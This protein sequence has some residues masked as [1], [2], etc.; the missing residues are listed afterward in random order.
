MQLDKR[1]REDI[2]QEM[3]ELAAGYTPEWKFRARQGDAGSALLNCYS[4]MLVEMLHQYNRIPELHKQMFFQKLGT[5][6]RPAE[7]AQGYVSFGLIHPEAEGTPV[8]A[9]TG[10]WGTSEDGE[11]VKLETQKEIYVSNNRIEQVMYQDGGNDR[12]Y[13]LAEAEGSLTGFNG[14][15][16]QEHVCWLGHSAVF[17][18][19]GEAE[20]LISFQP[21]PGNQNW[22]D[23]IQNREKT[24]FSY[25]S[26]QGEWKFDTWSCHSHII[27]LKKTRD[28]PDFAVVDE[29]KG[30]CC[31]LKWQAEDIQAYTGLEVKNLRVGAVSPVLLPDYVYTAEGQEVTQCFFPFGERPYS[32]GECYICS[33]E[34]FEKRGAMVHL[35]LNIEFRKR[36]LLREPVPLPIHWKAIMK[37]SDF[38][39]EECL[40]ITVA[41]VVWEYYNGTGFTRLFSQP[42]YTDI[43][44]PLLQEPADFEKPG[45]RLENISFLCPTD[46]VPIPVNAETV[47]CVRIRILRMQHEYAA[48]G[49]YLSPFITRIEASYDYE[50]SMQEPELCRCRNN[51]EEYVHT[52]EKTFAPFLPQTDSQSGI[53]IGFSKP[54][55]GGPY[56]IYCG[57]APRSAVNNSERWNYEY[58]NGR[59]WSSLVLEDETGNLTQ[60]GTL[61]PFGNYDMQALPLFGR[62]RY[63]LRLLLLS[64]DRIAGTGRLP[65]QEVW[66]NTVSVAAVE[67]APEE[68]LTVWEAEGYL[69]CKLKQKNIRQ[70]QVWVNEADLSLTE[71]EQ[72][73]QE[74]EVCKVR[75]EAGIITQVW[76]LWEETEDI[77][78]LSPDSRCYH[79]ER[80]EGILQFSGENRRFLREDRRKNQ[81]KAV[82]S[83][84]GGRQGNLAAG[85]VTHMN[86]SIRFLNQVVNRHKL[87]GGKDEELPEEAMLRMEHQLLHR[88]RAVMPGDYEA[89][90][91]ESAREVTRVK[92]FANRNGRGE[93][94]RGAITLVVLQEDPQEEFQNL[95]EVIDEYIRSRMPGIRLV[96]KHFYIVEPWFTEIQVTA[97]CRI[98]P[99]ASVFACKAEAEERLGRFLNPLTGNSDG[100]G[101]HIGQAPRR[102]QLRNVLH[103]TKGILQLRR[104]VVKAYCR[105]EERL[106]EVN[107]EGCLPEFLM[108]MNGSH[109]L[110]MEFSDG[111]KEGEDTGCCR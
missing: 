61:M 79:V 23:V 13:C 48:K 25:V 73:E 36:S 9:G 54:L 91:L 100:K 74:T 68:Y 8:P 47:Y 24:G 21:Q 39:K 60:S 44:A 35:T 27:R 11:Q 53:Y 77:R 28:M 102:E 98:K 87:S 46:M 31:L 78:Q 108:V 40:P 14:E 86:R 51:L 64:S 12:I 41:E 83:R 50:E 55:T 66:M 45:A 42:L 70:I 17:H 90:A 106:Q 110:Q 71:Q 49:Y 2:I 3:E 58:Y 81:V 88:N 84:G 93:G 29:A 56:G 15:N 69:S 63:W 26:Q 7:P 67:Q 104:M 107:L 103:K 32:Y 20:L 92:A 109:R 82:Y 59:E 38:P 111:R 37:Q 85:Q 10:L 4:D 57:I 76:V 30:P 99:H 1:T 6:Q 95:Q 22:D 52:K 94:Q 105:R 34:V 72:L 16:L 18:I 96:Q 5:K 80:R 19:G 43:C 97:V 89:L 33:N 101:W 65:I 62:E 75:N